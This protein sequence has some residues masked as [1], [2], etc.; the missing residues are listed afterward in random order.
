MTYP[1]MLAHGIARFDA[2]LPEPEKYWDDIPLL[3]QEH[4]YQVRMAV[5]SWIGSVSTRGNELA[6]QVIEYREST[7]A[8]KINIIAHS[9]GG[10]DARYA[11]AKCDLADKVASL[12]TLGTPHLVD[13]VVD[14]EVVKRAKAA[15]IDRPLRID[16]M[17]DLGS[18]RYQ[19][20]TGTDSGGSR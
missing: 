9:M 4:D 12:V 1:I 17:N 7:R 3:L 11:I 19:G 20:N 10:L 15:T 14:G 16:C 5:V 8:Q 18:R 13:Q 2:F 6:R